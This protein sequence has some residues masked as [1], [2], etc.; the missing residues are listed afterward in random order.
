MKALALNRASLPDKTPPILH[1]NLRP[2]FVI[3]LWTILFSA[4][5]LRGLFFP[6][7]LLTAHILVGVVFALCV[8]DQVLRREADFR[9]SGL[10]WALVA[11]A[12]AYLLS[13][14]TA[15]HI[16][17]AVGE[18]LKVVSYL[19][20]FWIAFR[21][22]R[23]ERDLDRVLLVTYVGALG[24]AL[25][26]IAATTGL[27]EFPGAVVHGRIAST[28]QYPNTLGIFLAMLSVV[29]VALSVKTDRL[30]PKLF[31]AVGGTILVT[32]ILG[33][34]S[35][36]SWVVYP[37]ILGGFAALL[38]DAY[39]WRAAYH[40]LI[41]VSCGL[42]AAKGFF[43]ALKGGAPEVALW[44][45]GAGVAA[46][47]VLQ[48]GY[49][50]LGVW[51]N[52]EAVADATR[53]LVAWG[54]V[55]YCGLV[56]ALYLMY[57]AAAMPL[58]GGRAL[59]AEDVFVR[60]G[61]ISGAELSFTERM[62]M[63]RDALRIVGDYPLT[64]AGGGGW[65]A[66]YHQYQSYPYWTTEAHNYFFQTWVEAGTAGFVAVLAL[67]GFF[68]H[69]LVRLWRYGVRNG[70]WVS[71]WA[72]AV[73]A[74]G[75]GFHSFFDFNL[76]MAAVGFL[77]FA[78]L[79][80]VRAGAGLAVGARGTVPLGKKEKD[81]EAA[82]GVSA[83]RLA[84]IALA[85][86][87]AAAALVVPASSL[88]AAGRLGAEGALAMW[89]Q[90]LDTAAALLQEAAR[91]DPFTATYPGDL[92]QI[93]A[94]QA[95]A[96]DDAA[97]RY[98]AIGYARRAA[99]CEPYG[100][101]IRSSNLNVYHMLREPRLVVLEAE[102]LPPTNPLHL[103]NYEILGRAYIGAMH[104]SIEREEW[105]AARDY[106]QKALDLPGRVE[107]QAAFLDRRFVT[108]WRAAAEQSAALKLV[109]GQAHFLLG[110]YGPAEE[111]LRAAAADKNLNRES[112]IWRA[113]AL[114]RM[115][116]EAPAEE[117]LTRLRAEE[118]RGQSGEGESPGTTAPV[119]GEGGSPPGGGGSPP[120]EGDSPPG[121]QRG[122]SPLGQSPW[123]SVSQ[124]FKE[125]LALP[126]LHREVRP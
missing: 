11:L 99:A 60:A 51:L 21:A 125:V 17:P 84:L 23:A 65:N 56:L 106:A 105:A 85:G 101:K 13:L 114:S 62:T 121:V 8:Y 43:D 92:A 91:R 37:F 9:F 107:R 31:F 36:G 63:N 49:H 117:I 24:V 118:E 46:A 3:G 83:R 26:G 79:G 52:R 33:T 40:T 22:V 10:E 61:Q 25:V 119:V 102:A 39:R 126:V 82:P 80:L 120:G 86:T 116:E 28:L 93:Y 59:L 18:V 67:W 30:W 54:G 75:L 78:Y 115:G 45:L 97:K 47:C 70:M 34:Q 71:A 69:W 44:Y 103:P 72:A 110:E 48:A 100:I 42:L 55:G 2:F 89:R 4:P 87:L 73:A 50:G 90:D 1:L 53:R 111:R 64:G 124:G 122:Q 88:Y 104:Y 81:P 14:V 5:F 77:L 66:L 41:Q 12:A 15:V 94:V 6:P 113:A 109:T 123:G 32:V 16:R 68:I 74:L 57:A 108:R 98:R 112:E 19:M 7:E 35:R 58:A 38:P 96:E 20:I 76:S 29:G 95:L 27:F